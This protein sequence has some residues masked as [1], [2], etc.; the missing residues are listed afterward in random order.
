MWLSSQCGTN[1]RNAVLII[2]LLIHLS[3]ML[4]LFP[5]FSLETSQYQCQSIIGE[6]CQAI[7]KQ[8]EEPHTHHLVAPTR[9]PPSSLRKA[10]Q[11]RYEEH[12]PS[13]HKDEEE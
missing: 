3:N 10:G 8:M 13:F 7:F 4:H 1:L 2:S 9:M 5:L 11:P 6:K 12:P